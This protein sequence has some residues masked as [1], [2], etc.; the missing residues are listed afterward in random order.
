MELA[1][2]H[3]EGNLRI[4]GVQKHGNGNFRQCQSGRVEEAPERLTQTQYPGG[5]IYPFPRTLLLLGI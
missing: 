3:A 5:K 2:L 1:L 4:G